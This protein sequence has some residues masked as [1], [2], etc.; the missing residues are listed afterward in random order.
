[1]H[2]LDYTPLQKKVSW[3]EAATFKIGKGKLPQASWLAIMLVGLL[4]V[5]FIIKAPIGGTLFL[6]ALACLL[7]VAFLVYKKKEVRFKAF[8]DANGFEYISRGEP[9]IETGSVFEGGHKK[10]AKRIVHGTYQ[11][12]P[13]WFGTYI[14]STG[15][16]SNSRTIKL[17][18]MSIQLARHMPHILIDSGLQAV[19]S[20]KAKGGFVREG[21]V[22]PSFNEIYSLLHK[23]GDEAVVH[24]LVTPEFMHVLRNGIP[25]KVDIEICG[26]RMY[27]YTGMRIE[28]DE[29]TIKTLFTILEHLPPSMASVV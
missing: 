1:M 27:I 9:G 25:R 23:E 4:T 29:K 10:H 17:G 24:S 28:P 22:D 6:L 14:Y 13:F 3:Q 7:F 12:H 8:A 2:S 5:Y 19:A 11:D 20:A 18:V 21:N 15:L 16:A 26:N